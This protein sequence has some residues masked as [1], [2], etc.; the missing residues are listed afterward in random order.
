YLGPATT[1]ILERLGGEI[2]DAVEGAAHA[3]LY[4]MKVVAPCGA[5]MCGRFRGGRRPYSFALSRTTFDTMLVA[6]AARA[7]AQVREATTLEN[8]L[9]EGGAVAGVTARAC[10][11]QR[12]TWNARVVVGADGLRSVVARRLG[13][14]RSS[15]PRRVALAAHVADVAGI[16]G[17]GELHGSERGYVG[18]GPI[19]GGI[20]TVA[21]VVPL[22][23][24]RGWGRRGGRDLRTGFFAELER[25]PGLAGR[26]DPRRLARDVLATG[27]L[28]Q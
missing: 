28:A 1:E 24:V 10:N 23:T 26:F 22:T 16:D 21:L 20:T 7:G 6:A 17:V 2:L 8:L 25:F 15:P 12:V 27:P 5:A 19:G 18:L 3:K 14:I 4:G 9:W 11:G 13:L